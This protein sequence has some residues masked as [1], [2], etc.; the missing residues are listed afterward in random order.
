MPEFSARLAVERPDEDALVDRDRRF[1]WAEV[2]SILNRVANRIL[3]AD[4]G[5]QHRVAVFAENSAETA[6]AHLGCLLGGASTV[7]VN[8]HLTAPEAAYILEDSGTRVLFVGPE[9]A[10]AGLGRGARGRGRHGGGLDRR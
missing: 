4:L 10:G 1:G 6:L 5:D 9:T 7:P 3:G 2:D 8:F